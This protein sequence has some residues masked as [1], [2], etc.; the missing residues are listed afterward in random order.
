MQRLTAV[1]LCLCLLLTGCGWL[2]G[3]YHSVTPHQQ[4]SG[5]SDTKTETAENYLQLRTAMENMVFSGIE[6]RVISVSDFQDE[7][8]QRALEMAVRYVKST[9]P[10]GAYAVEDISYEVGTIGSTTAVA[11]KITY[12]HERSEIQKIRKVDNMDQARS[13][14][15]AAIA[16]CDANLVML[17]DHYSPTDVQQLVD[18][19]AQANPSAVMETPEVTEQLYPDSGQERVWTLRFTYQTSRDDLRIMQGQVER[20]FNS[21]ALYVSQDAG[22]ARKLSQL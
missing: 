2:D 5:S 21:A 12:R 10:I 4:H 9:D 17:V 8:L 11:V 7:Q 1:F 18:D 6:N 19:Y 14:I 13:L 3:E 15:E 22:D 20:I 16:N